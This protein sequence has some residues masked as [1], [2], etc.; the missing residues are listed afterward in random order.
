ME[1]IKDIKVPESGEKLKPEIKPI[2]PPVNVPKPFEQR[3]IEEKEEL[4]KAV[5]DAIQDLSEDTV[6]SRDK[7]ALEKRKNRSGG[8]SD[9]ISI[10]SGSLDRKSVV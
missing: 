3:E 2:K 6:N 10:E 7:I 9:Y 1:L 4:E 8:N 5:S